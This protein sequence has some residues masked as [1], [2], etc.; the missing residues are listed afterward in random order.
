MK[1]IKTLIVLMVLSCLIASSQVSTSKKDMAGSWKG[2]LAISG[3]QLRLVFNISFHA[4]DSLSATMD[5][6]DQ[7]AKNLTMGK[8]VLD[9]NML[10]IMAPF[11]GGLYSGT[12]E[13]DSTI[14]GTWSQGGRNFPLVLKRLNGVFVLGRPQEPK[15]PFPYKVE[16]VSFT[17]RVFNITLSGTLTIPEGEGPFPA[18]VLITGSGA[19]N[20]DEALMGHKP[21]LV[22][23]D[24]LTRKGIAV[25]RYD[26]RGVG[27]S[28]GNYAEST[29][30]DLATD[31]AAALEFLEKDKRINTSLTGLIGHSE[32]GLI[33]PIVAAGNNRVGF[34]VSLAGTGVNG[35]KILFRQQADISRLS[36]VSEKDIEEA[37]SVNSKLYSIVRKEKNNVKAEEKV[38]STYGKMLEKNV[39]DQGEREKSIAQLK[40]GFG[41]QTYT[42]FRF[43]LSADPA[44]YWKK[45]RCPVLAL[46][47]DKDLQVAAD[48][49]L[50]A[51]EKALSS[52]GNKAV[53]TIKLPG[54]NH[55]FQ[56]CTTGLPAE[57]GQIEET[58]SPEALEIISGWINGLRD[59]H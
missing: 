23:A 22:I 41:A 52:S 56:H 15:A 16:E 20:R 57:Y 47:G 14:N 37:A 43:F 33:A 45:V 12:I 34:I 1:K 48:I 7:G 17:N 49:N 21:F 30:A 42:W 11:I 54:L 26:D 10:K 39:K 50:P 5:S 38:L 46:N 9:K 36:G 32:G 24:W 4:P 55:L 59:R 6:P 58:F 53:K 31:V 27:K 13:N 8:V 40:A 19:Q 18:V 35:E 25:L 3:I 29:S 2:A 44:T 28:Q 51:I